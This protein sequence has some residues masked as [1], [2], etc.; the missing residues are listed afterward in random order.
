MFCWFRDCLRRTHSCLSMSG[1]LVLMLPFSAFASIDL[2]LSSKSC[3]PGDLIELRAESSFKELTQFELKFP[4]LDSVHIV[5][6]ERQPLRYEQGTYRQKDVWLFQPVEPGKI[7]FE[8]LKAVLQEGAE[9]SEWAFET[10]P[11][12]TVSSYP[13]SNDGVSAEQLPVATVVQAPAGNW[14]VWLISIVLSVGVIVSVGL[15]LRKDPIEDATETRVDLKTLLFEL[16]AERLPL[17]L[18]EAL[19]A[20]ESLQLSGRLRLEM[21]RFVYSKSTSTKELKVLLKEEV[22]S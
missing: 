7:G 2:S 11:V 17:D 6:H 16:E 8:G 14:I 9:S 1:I 10:L 4:K 12:L 19:L 20:D 3:L 18:C 22:R 5:A 15:L 13:E 21:E